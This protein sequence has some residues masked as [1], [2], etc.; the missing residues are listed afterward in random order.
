MADDSLKDL[1]AVNIEPNM[2]FILRIKQGRHFCAL[3]RNAAF[4]VQE[5]WQLHVKIAARTADCS[6]LFKIFTLEGVKEE[7]RATR[8]SP[9]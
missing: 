8:K 4:F 7:G 1:H 5:I 9:Y 3:P 6:S 2:N